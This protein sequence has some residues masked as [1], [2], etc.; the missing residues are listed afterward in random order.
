MLLSNFLMWASFL[1]SILQK[2]ALKIKSGV[3]EIEEEFSNFNNIRKLL[4]FTDV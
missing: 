4:N 1:L 2:R 3:F